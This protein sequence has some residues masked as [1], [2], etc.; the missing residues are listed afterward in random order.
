MAVSQSTRRSTSGKCPLYFHKGT[1][2]WCKTVS[3]RRFYFGKD[4][5]EALQRWKIEGEDILAGRKPRRP[6]PG[7]LTLR[8]AANNFLAAKEAKRDA[9]ELSHRHFDDLHRACA[10]V[11]DHFGRGRIVEDL[12]PDD[13]GQLRTVMAKRWGP[14]SLK[15]EITNVRQLFRFVYQ[16]DDVEKP[17][18]FG[19]QFSV[20]DKKALRKARNENGDRMFTADEIRQLLV[21]ASVQ[22]RAMILLASNAG[23]G[24]TDLAFLTTDRIDLAAGWLDYPRRKTE[25]PRRAK[26]WPETIKAI[27]AALAK[28]P[29]P[30]Q[31]KHAKLVFVTKYGGPWGSEDSC[32]SPISKEFRKLLNELELYRRGRSFYS[33]RHV[34]ATVG[35]EPGD[36]QAVRVVLGHEDGSMLSEQYRHTFPDNRLERVAEHVRGWLFGGEGTR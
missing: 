32:D 24:N 6:T 1:G 31:P 16:N 4:K 14:S 8:E 23:L 30:K 34:F 3:G 36:E 12:R 18:E 33:L 7:G 22:M 10:L 28:R 26:L 11:I 15:R 13:F 29:K 20:P 25:M 17:V 27:D 35:S 2:Q 19:T 5:A 9:G 21:A